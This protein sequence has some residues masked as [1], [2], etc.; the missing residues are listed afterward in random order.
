MLA[1][2]AAEKSEL[3]LLRV[4]ANPDSSEATNPGITTT[5]K[6]PLKM[7]NSEIESY[8]CFLTMR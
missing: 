1:N 4:L 8:L 6:S 7:R 3:F 5:S 2:M